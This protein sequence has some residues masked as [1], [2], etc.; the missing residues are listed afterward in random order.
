VSLADALR[1]EP[2]RPDP[3]LV[4][5]RLERLA[6]HER[7]VLELRS[8]L[9]G[10]HY[11]GRAHARRNPMARQIEPPNQALRTTASLGAPLCLGF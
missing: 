9:R 8:L 11:I 5:E 3:A 1:L 10:V 6:H 7:G 2:P 4:E